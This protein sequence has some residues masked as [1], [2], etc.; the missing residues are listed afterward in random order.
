MAGN[1]ARILWQAFLNI[2]L[3]EITYEGVDEEY[4]DEEHPNG[5]D[6]EHLDDENLDEDGDYVRPLLILRNFLKAIVF[7][8]IFTFQEPLHYVPQYISKPAL[9]REPRR[10]RSRCK[11]PI[12]RLSG[13]SI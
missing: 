10:S 6:E 4:S 3:I 1:F 9:A 12:Q 5:E 11:R 2:E 13:L 7:T 8:E